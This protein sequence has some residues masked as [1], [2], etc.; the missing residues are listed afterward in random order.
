MKKYLAIRGD[1]QNGNGVI[2]IWE[3]LG[4]ANSKNLEGKEYRY[5][6]FICPCTG[7]IRA[8]FE[9]NM[10]ITDW[11]THSLKSFYEEYPYKTAEK[12]VIN[13]KNCT[14]V[15]TFWTGYTIRYKV[16]NGIYFSEYSAERI[17]ELISERLMKEEVVNADKSNLQIYGEIYEGLEQLEKMGYSINDMTCGELKKLLYKK[18]VG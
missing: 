14:I 8:V 11:E 12:L 3:M 9:E 6:Y 15:E 5:F 16:D 10:L 17:R 7:V 2:K 13:G 4:G 1:Y 18:V